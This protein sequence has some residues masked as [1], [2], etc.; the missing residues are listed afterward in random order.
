M[1]LVSVYFSIV[2]DKE[3][4]EAAISRRPDLREPLML[5]SSFRFSKELSE[6]PDPL[7]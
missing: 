1:D 2:D 7:P 3:D 5:K 6:L 4:G